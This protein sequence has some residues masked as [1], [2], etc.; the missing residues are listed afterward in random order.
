M[1]LFVFTPADRPSP[2]TT[3]PS[4]VPPLAFVLNSPTPATCAPAITTCPRPNQALLVARELAVHG[5][6]TDHG[7]QQPQPQQQQQQEQQQQAP[8]RAPRALHYDFVKAYSDATN[9]H[10]RHGK[11]LTCGMKFSP[12]V[13]RYL[14]EEHISFHH[15]FIE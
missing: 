3:E 1:Y 14:V 4:S 7:W 10:I 5:R 6:K 12:A 9:L 11:C 2:A 13:D 15:A 8:L